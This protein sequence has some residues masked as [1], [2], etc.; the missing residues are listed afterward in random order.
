MLTKFQM[1]MNSM[2]KPELIMYRL[3]KKS[4]DLVTSASSSPEQL[5]P[6]SLHLKQAPT[7]VM[8]RTPQEGRQ[9]NF[10][11]APKTALFLMQRATP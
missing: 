3:G 11:V 2:K 10:M 6:H 7:I 5:A 1:Q 4:A 9:P 8:T